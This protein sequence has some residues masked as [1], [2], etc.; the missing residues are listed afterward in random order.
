MCWNSGLKTT[1]ICQCPHAHMHK[2]GTVLSCSQEQEIS[3]MKLIMALSVTAHVAHIRTS[4]ARSQE[5]T[6]ILQKHTQSH[7]D[8]S[9]ART[10]RHT[11]ESTHRHIHPSVHRNG[12][13]FAL[14]GQEITCVCKSS[15]TRNTAQVHA[16]QFYSPLHMCL[17]GPAYLVCVCVFQCV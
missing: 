2:T 5:V 3:W 10:S 8:T 1:K 14:R 12:Q 7:P 11:K 16:W 15:E 6:L 17:H 13:M 4:Y 9:K